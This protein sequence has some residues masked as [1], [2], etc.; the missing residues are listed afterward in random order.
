MVAIPGLGAWG[1]LKHEGDL[2]GTDELSRG[3]LLLFLFLFLLLFPSCQ[4]GD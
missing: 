4:A 2:L 3:V 1:I